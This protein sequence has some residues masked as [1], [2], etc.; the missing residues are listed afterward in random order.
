[1]LVLTWSA[2]YSYGK[3][4]KKHIQDIPHVII[5]EKSGKES[6]EKKSII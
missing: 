6:H 3:K 5:T 4:K 2:H 1:M